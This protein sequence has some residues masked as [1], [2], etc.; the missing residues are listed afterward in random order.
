YRITVV[1][2]E[3][4]VLLTLASILESLRVPGRP[5]D[6]VV[7]ILALNP[8]GFR[9]WLAFPEYVNDVAFVL[10][11]AI[12]VKGLVDGQGAR[13]VLGQLLASLARQTGLL[14]VPLVVVWLCRDRG[15]QDRSARQRAGLAGTVA[16]IAVGTYAA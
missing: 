16:A 8:W 1:A 7:A 10:G 13:V 6:L 15:W 12:V 3:V 9:Y 4:A 2:I 14:L 5:A 11:L